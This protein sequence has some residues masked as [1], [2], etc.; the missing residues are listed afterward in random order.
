[1]GQMIGEIAH[2][3]AIR[4]GRTNCIACHDN[5]VHDEAPLADRFSQVI[6]GFGG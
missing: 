6:K 2:E 4:K 1:M 5:L 3:D